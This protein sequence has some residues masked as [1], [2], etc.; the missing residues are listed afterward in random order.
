[1]HN[2]NL[3]PAQVQQKKWHDKRIM[4][5]PCCSEQPYRDC[6]APFIE[7]HQLPP[8]PATLMRSRYS[9]FALGHL[10]YIQATMQGTAAKRFKRDEAVEWIA[11]IEW[12]KLIV[13]SEKMKTPTKGYVI[14]EAPYLFKGEKQIMREKSEFHKIEGRWFYVDGKTLNPH[15]PSNSNI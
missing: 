14:F 8:T 5:C 6:C 4:L 3:H 12:Q 10:D 7:E 9:A 2:L 1:L 11:N 15:S 13:V